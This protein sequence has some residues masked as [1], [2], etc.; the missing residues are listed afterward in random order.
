[1]AEVTNSRYHTI[2]IDPHRHA[3]DLLNTW[4]ARILRIATHKL[5]AVVLSV[6]AH[7]Y[8]DAMPVL[9]RLVFPGFYSIKAPFLCTAGKIAKTGHVCAD[10]VT[11]DG[12]IVKMA[13]IYRDTR[14]MESAFRRLADR[15][16]LPDSDRVEMFNAVKKWVVCDYRLDPNMDPMDPDAKRLIH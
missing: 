1:V 16:K 11:R 6:L 9:L 8:D 13:A 2:I 3:Q 4:Q 15:L 10:V 14:E 7:N 12:Q 5:G